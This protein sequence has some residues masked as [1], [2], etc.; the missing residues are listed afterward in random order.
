MANV[1]MLN[2]ETG[3]LFF[4]VGNILS[5]NQCLKPGWMPCQAN[6]LGSK[7]ICW[8]WKIS[9]EEVGEPP[10]PQVDSIVS[11]KGNMMTASFRDGSSIRFWQNAR[12][13]PIGNNGF[14]I[15]KVSDADG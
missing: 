15:A 13:F 4:E 6:N 9:G 7:I 5:P 8:W 14:R 2:D 12:L 11:F 3:Q 1:V 10:H